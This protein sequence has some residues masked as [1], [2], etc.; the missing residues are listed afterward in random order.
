MPAEGIRKLLIVCPT[1]VSDCLETLEEIAVEG[2]ESFIRSGG[3]SLTFI[4]CLNTN[5]LWIDTLVKLI[6]ERESDVRS[7]DSTVWSSDPVVKS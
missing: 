2:K 3:E 1:F 5:P 6:R 4:P 7:P